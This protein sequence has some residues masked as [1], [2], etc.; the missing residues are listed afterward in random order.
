MTTGPLRAAHPDPLPAKE[1]YLA[2]IPWTK[3][4]IV[5]GI[6]LLGIAWIGHNNVQSRKAIQEKTQAYI[7]THLASSQQRFESYRANVD[8]HLRSSIKASLTQ[9]VGKFIAPDL[10]LADME[11]LRNAPGLFAKIDLHAYQQEPSLEASLIP[12][13]LS[14]FTSCLGLSPMALNEF[15]KR[16]SFLQSK[17]YAL[18]AQEANEMRLRVLDHQIRH[19]HKSDLPDLEK[20]MQSPWLWIVVVREAQPTHFDIRLWNL[21]RKS[22][23]FSLSSQRQGKLLSVRNAAA[24]RRASDTQEAPSKA[25]PECAIAAEVKNILTGKFANSLP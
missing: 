24:N 9:A 16:G 10:S 22:L 4:G 25:I 7:Q 1:R 12:I 6:V 17:A 19:Q 5:A 21:Q 3:L 18:E 14:A 2:H 11:S 8:K 15:D 23:I 20:V 13:G